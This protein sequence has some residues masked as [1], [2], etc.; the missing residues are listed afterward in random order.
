[1]R[2][3]VALFFSALLAGCASTRPPEVPLLPF[4]VALVPVR[5][6]GRDPGTGSEKKAVELDPAR[7]SE[8]LRTALVE[9][10]GFA[11]VTLLPEPE[12]GLN[13]AAL[14]AHWV[15]SARAVRADL[16]LECRLEYTTRYEG[17]HN[18]KFWLNLPLFLLGGPF[19]WFVD[20]RTYRSGAE[21]SGDLYDLALV[22]RDL[23]PLG[24]ARVRLISAASTFGETSMDFLDRA[25]G[26]GY[27][28]VSLVW[29]AGLLAMS[30]EEVK[31]ELERSILSELS[32]DF[33]TRVAVRQRDILEAEGMVN[34]WLEPDPANAPPLPREAA[35][36]RPTP[37]VALDQHEVAGVVRLRLDEDVRR[38]TRWRMGAP[39]EMEAAPWHPFPEP[40]PPRIAKVGGQDELVIEYPLRQALDPALESVCLELE[41]GHENRFTRTYT[42]PLTKP[43]EEPRAE[44]MPVSRDRSPTRMRRIAG[45]RESP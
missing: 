20:D 38:M 36:P 27:Y 26:A 17:E 6:V 23:Y 31:Q 18:E 30:T 45:P 34:F 10:G 3:R 8:E 40:A 42:I 37:W 21:L 33:A 2:A 1:M 28:L 32:R 41:D 11:A 35:A 22:Y 7:A 44:P 19:C 25:D 13:P 9:R 4:H 39:D 43:V 15:E 16:L 14:D 24:S 29:P 5:T 12:P